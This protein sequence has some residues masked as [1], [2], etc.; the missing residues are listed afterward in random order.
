M[1]SA[2]VCNWG[3]RAKQSS[4]KRVNLGVKWPQCYHFLSGWSLNFSSEK[5]VQESLP[6]QVV[7]INGTP[8]TGHSRG[9]SEILPL[10]ALVNEIY[11]MAVVDFTKTNRLL[12]QKIG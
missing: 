4:K 12:K 3:F 7:R 5:E 8:R 1:T 2:G 9:S 6:L 10:F 11:S